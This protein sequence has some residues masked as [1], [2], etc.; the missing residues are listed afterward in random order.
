MNTPSRYTLTIA[1]P[2]FNR[3]A[4]LQ[5]A[6]RQA[7]M[8]IDGLADVQ[9]LVSDNES[10]DNTRAV[11][12]AYMDR[13]N[14][15]YF[16]NP[17]NVGFDKNYLNCVQK[18][19]A[20]YVWVAGDDDELD[21][22]AIARVLEHIRRHSPSMIVLNGSQSNEPRFS[23]VGGIDV[24]NDFMDFFKAYGFH[25]TW[26]TTTILK[27]SALQFP[28]KNVEARSSGFI[29][30]ALHLE[31][32]L[33]GGRFVMDFEPLVR[34][35]GNVSEYSES[36][37]KMAEL[38]ARTLCSIMDMY[39]ASMTNDVQ[40]AFLMGHHVHYGMFRMGY[41]IQARASRGL[42]KEDFQDFLPY[43]RRVTKAWPAGW[44]AYALP[45][46]LSRLIVQS[47]SLLVRHRLRLSTGR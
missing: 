45:A 30:I 27:T 20:D 17:V 16:R 9:V 38:F 29:H 15:R 25:F 8:S 39:A 14:F 22:K 3:A 10:S 41:F 21:S 7:F 19:D 2:T 44:L 13:P 24:S 23:K 26:I 6:L 40:V 32:F 37:K 11:C 4:R 34:T 1:I 42:T 47:R 46:L 36:F 33:H 18:S 35:S 43:F 12:A 28:A 5:A 31:S